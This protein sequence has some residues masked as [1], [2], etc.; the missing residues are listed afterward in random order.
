[1]LTAGLYSY[2]V[3]GPDLQSLKSALESIDR[4]QREHGRLYAL[5][6]LEAKTNVVQAVASY[7]R[8]GAPDY[9]VGEQLIRLL[10]QGVT[11]LQREPVP[12]DNQDLRGRIERAIEQANAAASDVSSAYP[13]NPNQP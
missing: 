2:R 6:D 1:M 10:K 13:K 7:R 11:D 5:D 3:Y 4:S 9:F 12:A 8:E